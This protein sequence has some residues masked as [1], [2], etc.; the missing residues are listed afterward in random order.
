MLKK[1]LLIIF[2]FFGLVSFADQ[3]YTLKSGVSIVNKV[4]TGFYGTWRVKSTRVSTTNEE[5]FKPSTID[6]WNL[7]KVGDVITIENPFSGAKASVSLDSVQGQE[8][9]FKKYGDFDGGKLTDIVVLTL[10][11][12]S[13]SGKNFLTID[14]PSKNDKTVI[15]SDK[16]V[17][18][19]RGEKIS[20][21]SL[22]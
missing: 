7:S 10:N 19:L 3:N 13:F 18:E 15:K 4:P 6:L 11:G 17:Y 2:L 16:A 8:I 20:G 22:K 9:K 12:D 5:L 14:L 21:S 1:V